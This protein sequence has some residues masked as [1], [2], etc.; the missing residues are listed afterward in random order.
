MYSTQSS[1]KVMTNFQED[2]EKPQ[3]AR[4]CNKIF[5]EDSLSTQRLTFSNEITTHLV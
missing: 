5:I 4:I 2:M 1:K 3:K